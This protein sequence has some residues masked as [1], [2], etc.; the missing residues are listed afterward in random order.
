MSSFDLF[1]KEFPVLANLGT[2]AE[3]YIYSDPNSS[4]YKLRKIGE[5]ITTLIYQYD[6]LP[7]PTGN[8]KDIAQVTRLNT[9]F[10]YRIITKV[11]FS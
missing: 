2:L 5:A 10:D 9:L 11:T 8:I 3:K 1:E 6:N 7:V 4:L